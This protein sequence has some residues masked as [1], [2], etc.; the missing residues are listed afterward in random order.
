MKAT[1]DHLPVLGGVKCDTPQ[2]HRRIHHQVYVWVLSDMTPPKLPTITSRLSPKLHDGGKLSTMISPGKL[3]RLPG[4]VIGHRQHRTTETFL[5]PCVL[6]FRV[7]NYEQL[8]SHRRL[9]NYKTNP[10]GDQNAPEGIL[11]RD[12]A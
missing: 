12:F 10:G 2:T 8:N 3:V 1:S 5:F 11:F 7:E 9:R 6:D 4:H